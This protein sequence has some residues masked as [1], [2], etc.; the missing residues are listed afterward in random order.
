MPGTRIPDVEP[1]KLLKALEIFDNEKRQNMAGWED[2]KSQKYAISHEDKLYPPKE[3]I[4][5]ATGATDFYGGDESNG[6]LQKRGLTIVPLH[7]GDNGTVRYWVEL[8]KD[9]ATGEINQVGKMLVSP[10]RGNDNS[11]IYG[12]MRRV[13]PG[14]VIL[15]I[16]A[17]RS[18]D[19]VS[20]VASKAEDDFIFE[21][22]KS[23]R[24]EL[25]DYVM[26][27]QA[28]PGYLLWV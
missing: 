17:N 23:Y 4:R 19:G 12:N 25:D 11:D 18:L 28:P 3:I 8:R 2:K 26:L 5:I 9:P 14:D 20:V 21:G 13:K 7:Q 1:E 16:V 27:E 6:Y 15:H 24:V 10:L 22:N